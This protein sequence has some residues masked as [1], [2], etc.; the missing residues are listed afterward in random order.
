MRRIGSVLALTLLS[1]LLVPTAPAYAAPPSRP[2]VAVSPLGTGAGCIIQS[3]FGTEHGKPGNFE[4]V[5]LEGNE[6]VHYWHPNSDTRLAWRRGLVVSR[7]ATGPGCIIQSSFGTEF[8]RPGNLEVVVQEGSRLVHYWKDGS[9][10]RSPW[11]RGQTFGTGVTSGPS[12]IQSSLKAPGAIHGNF[13]VVVREGNSLVHYWHD[14]RNPAN[15]WARGATI[16]TTATG[17]GSI[18]QSSITPAP[19]A[20]GNFE[21]V[22]QEGSR[23]RALL[24]RQPQPEQ[25]VGPGRAPSPP[26]SPGRR[27]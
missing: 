11:V 16:A 18:Y 6:L 27:R 7:T 4:V 1:A 21:V 5:V 23:R 9:V 13:E 17:G 10:A 12:F 8:G 3:S 24:A 20:P 14:N 15:P 19:G 26:A 22:F 25:P 2:G